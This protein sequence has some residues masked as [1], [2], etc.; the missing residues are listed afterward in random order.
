M[1]KAAGLSESLAGKSPECLAASEKIP[2]KCPSGPA[3]G[4]YM[5]DEFPRSPRDSHSRNRKNMKILAA[6]LAAYAFAAAN[7]VVF[8]SSI[9]Q[10][11]VW[12]TK[13]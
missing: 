1:A 13:M 8:S 7:A 10:S 9:S 3:R 2:H 5:G 12:L 6:V 11:R 4:L